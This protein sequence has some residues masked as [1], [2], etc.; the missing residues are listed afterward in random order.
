MQIEK[1]QTDKNIMKL[2][3]EKIVKSTYVNFAIN[4]V[5]I[6]CIVI[7]TFIVKYNK[8]K[9]KCEEIVNLKV[10]PTR[11]YLNLTTPIPVDCGQSNLRREE[12]T[13]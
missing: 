7:I 9:Y 2:F 13:P 1:L 5:N 8:K 12:L 10:M 11:P 3:N 4:F 6:V